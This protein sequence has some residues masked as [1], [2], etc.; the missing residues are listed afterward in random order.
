MHIHPIFYL[1]LVGLCN[2]CAS[3]SDD[4]HKT[5]L[6][7]PKVESK[8][9]GVSLEMPSG[10]MKKGELAKVKRSN[11][12]WIAIIPY[13]YSKENEATV[14]YDYD[15]QWR[16]EGVEGTFECARMAQ[17]LGLKMML[18]PHV[19][20]VG[21]G[22]PGNFDLGSE[23]EWLEWEKTY[24]EYILEYAKIAD[25]MKIDLYSIGTEYRIAVVKRPRFWEKLIDEVR[26]IYKGKVTYASNWDNYKKV[27]F[28]SKLDC[29]GVDAYFPLSD[30]ANPT[31]EELKMAWKP[32][33]ADLAL[34]S[35]KESKPILFTE[36]GYKSVEHA[37]TRHGLH[38][39]SSLKT[40]PDNQ[41]LAYQALF[42]TIWSQSFMAGG[43]FWKWHLYSDEVVGGETNRRFTP[44]G[45]RAEKTIAKWYKGKS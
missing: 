38:E 8:I 5:E 25:S 29:I 24:R 22:W 37:T 39:E 41:Q 40:S 45:K 9:N 44:Q 14:H 11:C 31:L 7:I 6:K 32:I 28:W 17:E 27:C 26:E 43:F 19:W 34:L 18:K 12:E 2:S 13:A 1:I 15:G 35:I 36:Y 3:K 23:K 4:L 33:E 30:K 20:V 42:E 10:A 16:G 21:Q